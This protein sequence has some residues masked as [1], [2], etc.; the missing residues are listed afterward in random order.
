MTQTL[1]P[2]AGGITSTGDITPTQ[3]RVA[4]GLVLA[5]VVLLFAGFSQEQ[6]PSGMTSVQ[7]VQDSYGSGNLTRILTGGYIESLSFV[8]LLPALVFLA[9]AY[10]TRTEGSRWAAQ[11][12]LIAGLGYAVVTLSSGMPPGAASLYGVQHGAA[13]ETALMVN[14]IRL[15]AFY[16]SLL[17]LG[18]QALSLGIAAL[19]ERRH[20][21]WVGIGGIVT[22]V[23]LVLGVAGVRWGLH[24]L[25]SMVWMVWFVGIGILLLRSASAVDPDARL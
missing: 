25:A 3:W 6:T 18:A 11:T 22:G 5:H 13:L 15:F 23:V 16:L 21:R 12:S 17:L 1:R 10:G 24:D 14:N 2:P 7:S 8:V 4:G 19:L 20:P 9:R